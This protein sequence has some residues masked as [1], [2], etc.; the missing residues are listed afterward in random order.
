MFINALVVSLVAASVTYVSVKF[1]LT[2]SPCKLSSGKC[3]LKDMN[4]DGYP[5][6][7]VQPDES[8]GTYCIDFSPYQFEVKICLKTIYLPISY[9]FD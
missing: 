5:S 7:L 8:A 6:T 2:P 4:N 3:N 1:L 9:Y